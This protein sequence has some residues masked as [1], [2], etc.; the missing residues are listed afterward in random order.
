MQQKKK[1]VAQKAKMPTSKA[2]H[3]SGVKK[4][5]KLKLPKAAKAK[6]TKARKAGK[7]PSKLPKSMN[8]KGGMGKQP[9][10]PPFPGAAPPLE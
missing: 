10:P 9:P 8:V 3:K 2:M 5:G 7:L 1:Q 6:A 4:M